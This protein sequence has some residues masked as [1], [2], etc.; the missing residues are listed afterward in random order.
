[1]THLDNQRLTE[2]AVA[3][4]AQLRR[5]AGDAFW[6]AVSRALRHTVD[7]AIRFVSRERRRSPLL[8]G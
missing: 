4:A 2:L 3:R 5:E 7:N 1:M 6:Q 8:E